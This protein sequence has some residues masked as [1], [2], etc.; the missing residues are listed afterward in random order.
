M[1]LYLREAHA[2]QAICAAAKINRHVHITNSFKR[3]VIL[4]NVIH[5]KRNVHDMEVLC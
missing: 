1:A 5:E 2:R 4:A 3:H